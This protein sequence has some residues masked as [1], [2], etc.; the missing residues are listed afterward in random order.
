MKM[1]ILKTAVALSL[2]IAMPSL[3][4]SDA[5]NVPVSGDLRASGPADLETLF[6]D[7]SDGFSRLHPQVRPTSKLKGRASASYALEMRTAEIAL[8]D[9]PLNPFELYGTYERSWTYPIQVEVGTASAYAIYVH[10]TNPLRQLTLAQIDGIFGAQR[11]GGW[12]RLAWNKAAA[13]GAD[14][15]IRRWG[16]LGVKGALADKPIHVLGAAIE[17][18]GALSGFQILAMQGGATWNEEYHEFVDPVAMFAA[19]AKDRLAIVYADVTSAP[20]NMVPLAIAANNASPF[21]KPEAASI[22]NRT[23]VLAR[24][25]Y[26]YFTVD[27][28]Q[29]DPAPLSPVIREFGRYVLSPEG[30]A[31]L[32]RTGRYRPLPSA[33]TL[34]QLAIIDSDASPSERPKP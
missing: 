31:K 30:Q 18:Q 23:Y 11:D 21:V 1:I 16:Q 19:L 15:N 29:G 8:M 14:K 33:Q 3:A 32:A 5:N 4:A 24:P 20:K 17:G 6:A 22:A 2:T 26:L 25:L 13:R 28:V 27:N 7:W 10:P 12:D 9:R 34:R